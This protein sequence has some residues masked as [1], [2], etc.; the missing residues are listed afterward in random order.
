M[1]IIPSFTL[2][3]STHRHLYLVV[4]IRKWRTRHSLTTRLIN[5][6]NL[7]QAR[8][9]SNQNRQFG[10][11]EFEVSIYFFMDEDYGQD[12]SDANDQDDGD[13][14]DSGGDGRKRSRITV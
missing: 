14:S 11:D 6:L 8:D 10:G 3:A 9:E 13:G 2:R 4:R 1:H 12:A 5:I 7:K